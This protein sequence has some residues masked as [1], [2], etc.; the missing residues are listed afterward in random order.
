MHIFI[1]RDMQEEAKM[2]V[3]VYTTKSCPYCTHVKDYLTKNGVKYTEYDVASNQKYAQEM[4]Q[5]TGQMGVPV[6]TIG[7]QSIVGFNKT[8]LN[9][10]LNIN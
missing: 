3:K 10:I 6:I 1:Y 7:S 4:I 2:N 9:S 5:K 8:K